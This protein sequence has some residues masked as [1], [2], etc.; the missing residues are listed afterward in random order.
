MTALITPAELPN[1]VPG[2]VLAASDEL[3]WSG[4]QFRAYRYAGLDV[5]VPAM[6]D[7]TVVSYARGATPM[8]RRFEGRWT[9]TECRPGDAS[10]L[11]RS[12]RSH[13]HWTA[14]IDVNHLYLSEA[15]V[16]RV[17]N[18]VM[19]RSVSEVRLLDVLKTNDPVVT[20]TV[21]AIAAEA[22]QRSLG[23]ALCVEAMGVRLVVHLLRNY[24]SVSF[25][26]PCDNGRLSPAQARR[27]VEYIDERL[28]ESASLEALAAVAGLGVWSFSRRFRATFGHPAHSY[29]IDRRVER[30]QALIR[31]GA[32][33]VKEVASAC[34]FADQAHM[35][36]VFQARLHTTPAVLRRQPQA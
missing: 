17:A 7:F 28:H 5:E 15:F 13:W 34:G 21:D 27:V 14:G 10:L 11:T 29:V 18:E 8:A 12:Q 19:D 35:T 2:L 26:E 23:G 25:R 31:Q 1:W 36:R 33:S 24:A 9:R 30:A 20:E 3:G 4:V 22:D 32:L 6:R 16:T